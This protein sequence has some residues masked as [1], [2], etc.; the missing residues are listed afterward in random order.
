[1][2]LSSSEYPLQKRANIKNPTYTNDNY[3]PKVKI[4]NYT[5]PVYNTSQS[6]LG[7]KATEGERTSPQRNQTPPPSIPRN[8][9][10]IPVPPMNNH[11]AP[12]DPNTRMPATPSFPNNQM[13]ISPGMPN[14][15][16]PATPNVPIRRNNSSTPTNNRIPNN[17]DNH[18]NWNDYYMPENSNNMFSPNNSMY[19]GPVGVPLMPLY[20]Y[21]NCE[22]AEKDWG[23]FRQLHP[24]TAKR[25]LRE[26]DE[27]CDKL[28]YD[29]SSMF[30]EY[31]D[32]V[33]LGKMID[34]IYNKVQG[35]IEEPLVYS[36]SIKTSSKCQVED[37]ELESKDLTS[38]DNV[39][40]KDVPD[41]NGNEYIKTNE[42]RRGNSRRD[43]RNDNRRGSNRNPVR[44]NNWVRDFIEILL[45]QELINRRRR[46]RSRR[47]WF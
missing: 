24:G 45:Y 33:H 34:R 41:N 9:T 10:T 2:K 5:T 42:Y 40:N 18:D 31:P 36:E 26:I 25:I 29:G 27:E 39:S 12:F 47:R 15:R 28:E 22:D 13:P 44:S 16:M 11:R 4:P 37:H 14:N 19:N 46:Y 32:R 3:T 23:Y 7:T 21:D 30:D 38:D 35:E 8:G 17:F 43:G 1:M 20:G 6:T